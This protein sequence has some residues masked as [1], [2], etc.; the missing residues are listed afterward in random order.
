MSNEI[1]KWADLK[2]MDIKKLMRGIYSVFDEG[3]RPEFYLRKYDHFID[4]EYP[5]GVIGDK[6]FN[7]ITEVMKKNGY[8]L[9]MIDFEECEID[10]VTEDM[11]GEEK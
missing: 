5:I 9:S 7:K 2:E 4:I 6:Q 1:I 11:N 10:F 8:L 3:D